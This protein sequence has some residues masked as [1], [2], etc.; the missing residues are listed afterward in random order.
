M[1]IKEDIKNLAKSLQIFKN[2]LDEDK[3]QLNNEQLCN[4][5]QV[6]LNVL[7]CP[8]FDNIVNIRGA[9]DQLKNELARHPSILP[10]D[11]EILKDGRLQLSDQISAVDNHIYGNC[12]PQPISIL[13]EDNNNINPALVNPNLTKCSLI[14]EKITSS[15]TNSASDN[16]GDYE[17]RRR[18]L[19]ESTSLIDKDIVEDKPS[20]EMVLNTEWVQV[21]AIELINDG[22]GLGFGIIGGRSTGV[23]VKNLTRGGPAD[24]DGRLQVGDHLLQINDI[25]IRGMSSEQV[26][27]VL[28]YVGMEVRLIV[29]RALDPSI[30]F[31]DL[32]T[33]GAVVPAHVLSDPEAIEQA[34]SQHHQQISESV[35][36][37]NSAPSTT[38][39]NE[40]SSM[41][42]PGVDNL[43]ET[44]QDMETLACDIDLPTK[45]SSSQ[46]VGMLR[47]P[48]KSHSEPFIQQQIKFPI[49]SKHK[50]DLP[51]M[52][53]YD[54]ELVKNQQGL[55]I[56]IA[57]YV[58]EKEEISG[59]FVKSIAPGSAADLCQKIEINDQIIEVDGRS[60]KNYTNHES[61]EV[62]RNTGKVVKLKLARY[63]RGVKYEQL[64]QAISDA[65]LEPPLGSERFV[66]TIP[67]YPGS[68]RDD[69]MS[70]DNY[71]FQEGNSD[72]SYPSSI[73]KVMEKS[74]VDKWSSILGPDYEIV[75]AQIRKFEE[76][77]GL[78]ISLEGTVDLEDGRK[79]RPHHYIRAILPDGPVG[80]NGL[81]RSGDE[82]LEVNGKELLRLD[83]SEVVPLL[84]ELPMNVCM[85]CA[86]S[87][88]GDLPSPPSIDVVD[89]SANYYRQSDTYKRFDEPPPTFHDRL[90]KTKSDGSLAINS[91]SSMEKGNRVKSRSLEPLSGS[92]LWADEIQ[93]IQLERG[94]RGLGFSIFDYQDPS[95]PYE[96]FIVIKDLVPGG[97]AE[98]D[99]R[100]N[101]GDRL[102]S[103]NDI[104]LG[105]SSLADA[106]QAL[107]GAPRGIVRIGV[108]KPLPLP[109]SIQQTP[110][111]GLVEAL[112]RIKG[113]NNERIDHSLDITDSS[114]GRLLQEEDEAVCKELC[115]LEDSNM[116]SSSST[117][118]IPN[119]LTNSVPPHSC[120]FS[121]FV[122]GDNILIST[123]SRA[124][125]PMD[126]ESPRSPT[127][128]IIC[129]T[130]VTPLPHALE[131]TLRVRKG[132]DPL[133]LTLEL[134]DRGINGMM[135]KALNPIGAIAKDGRLRVGDYLVAM[136][137]ESFRNVTNSQARAILRRAQL[138]SGDMILKYVPAEDVNV[139]KQ[140]T[141]L[142]LQHNNVPARGRQS[143][144]LSLIRRTPS[145][146]S[147]YFSAKTSES[148]SEE[149]LIS[150][151]ALVQS[152]CPHLELE[153]SGEEA[154]ITNLT[155]SKVDPPEHHLSSPELSL[156][157]D[158]PK[159]VDVKS[160]SSSP[161]SDPLMDVSH[162]TIS[163]NASSDVIKANV[164]PGPMNEISLD[165]N[166][167]SARSLSAA[168]VSVSNTSSSSIATASASSTL[169]RQW[170]A[171]KTIE[172]FREPD[173]GLGISIVGG[174][175]DLFN[176]S[177]GHSI[178]GIFIKNILPGSTAAKSGLLKR[179]D[180]ILEV[181]GKD[182]KNA[183]R[184]EAVEAIRNADNPIKFVVQSLLPLPREE[185]SLVS[186]HNGLLAEA[187]S[188][189]TLAALN[190][191]ADDDCPSERDLI[192]K[193]EVIEATRKVFQ[194]SMKVPEDVYHRR[195][196]SPVVIQEGLDDTALQ[197]EQA[198]MEMIKSGAIP[199]KEESEEN[200][201]T[202]S[203]ESKIESKLLKGKAVSLASEPTESESDEEINVRDTKG[204]VFTKAGV[205]IDRTSAGNV[206]TSTEE[207]DDPEDDFGYTQKKIQK[208]YGDLNGMVF[209]VELMKGPAGLGISLAGNRDRTK[210]S[211]FI[212]GM[213]PKGSAARDG[214]IQVSDEI[215]EVNGVVLY[216][217][218]HLNASAVIKSL[219]GPVYKII[220]L[221][222]EGALEEMAVK[223]L[224]QFPVHLEEEVLQ[225]KYNKFHGVRTVTVRKGATGLGI[226]II[227]GKHTEL[228]K[229]V[230]VSDIQEGSPAE[231][232]GLAVGDMILCVNQTDLI[233][234]DYDS[235]ASA[236]KN[237]EGLLSVVIAKPHRAPSHEPAQISADIAQMELRREQG[238][239]T[240]PSPTPSQTST[241]QPPIPPPKPTHLKHKSNSSLH[242]S[243]VN[244]NKSNG[245]PTHSTAQIKPISAH[246][247][248]SSTLRSI[249]PSSS[250][251]DKVSFYATPA[252]PLDVAHYYSTHSFSDHGKEQSDERQENP[253]TC[254]IECGRDTIIEIDKKKI[255][256]G[257]S[258]VGGS[259]TPLGA[260]IIHEV[261]PDGA[262]AVDGRL[263]PGDVILQVNDDDLH[264]VPHDQA[265]SALRQTT[266]SIRMVVH[267]EESH[268]TD[269]SDLY[270]ILTI[271]LNKKPG[272]GL[273]L[274]IVG[275]KNGPGV[276]VSEVVKGGVA[277]AD[278]RL[279]QGDHILQVNEHDLR[280]ATNADAAAILKT[281]M[282][283]IVMKIGRL[284]AGPRLSTSSGDSSSN[285][286]QPSKQD[287]CFDQEPTTKLIS[288]K[289]GVEGLGFS[290]VGGRGSP[291]GDFP[292]YVKNIFDKGAAAEDGRLQ[293]GDQIIAVNNTSL[294]DA[295]H[296]N[297]VE[298]LKNVSGVVELS[299]IRN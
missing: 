228:G 169:A 1:S 155:A 291:Y 97:L 296:E 183:T 154:L 172:L 197:E 12:P 38:L 238:L 215:L 189:T 119:R 82:I 195:T 116:Q 214:R 298:I 71:Y 138:I 4:D 258:V 49:D 254:Q 229:G 156:K 277:E 217:R 146:R 257:L 237:A 8:V 22:Q 6:L 73:N 113:P 106:V 143:P 107:K 179:G 141:L 104:N 280:N 253:K 80:K 236:L 203:K 161:K 9:L 45:T 93:F 5:V 88:T 198:R 235:A 47:I 48:V 182:L 123:D 96:T 133:G 248:S 13:P 52:E 126:Y 287:D 110:N 196:P 292:I 167:L 124:S 140:S 62:L 175:V 57:G 132:T 83:H 211:V 278:G 290:I 188:N 158:S 130:I 263:R 33:T 60:L 209:M 150:S 56:T 191:M 20:Q 213:H 200:E 184:D 221:R 10:L 18:K 247:S 37:L 151:D 255:G 177:P 160:A 293:R 131:R 260:V 273:G 103:V 246:T 30:D 227:E 164:P 109:E 41:P 275:K 274:S 101:P 32:Q 178:G 39:L 108:A 115:D 251:S 239:T 218:S 14:D 98:R 283:K 74:L 46:S 58:C 231:H 99:G 55:G 242:E 186:N 202:S 243:A 59:I 122:S 53:T 21:E 89:N 185:E 279:L 286:N 105:A 222:R 26:A 244:K 64:Q 289:K 193:P 295:T 162:G 135:I 187:S 63:L 95:N 3:R 77:G 11:F 192:S 224:T 118:S 61:V 28:R 259:D 102:L 147:P 226:M 204:K 87:K 294:D 91:P 266:S 142:A 90:V 163:N 157:T 173:Q 166:L 174:R 234:A 207:A 165:S 288:L 40:G 267:R 194:D 212:C 281:T 205:E 129:P 72:L 54:V 276:Y 210:M 199:S 245:I 127:S 282:G 181:D 111:Q 159:M 100:L 128:S 81:L 268:A 34:L 240:S 67:N 35:C 145:P 249:S 44:A 27:Q 170:S 51:E 65:E 148:G 120:P 86:R 168:N 70:L 206:K 23:I 75:V 68:Q 272:K 134:A 216:G 264:N 230:F 180:H 112:R 299:I 153:T 152:S 31:R 261:Y 19:S 233:G 136:N 114:F 43:R 7:E 225:E 50:I 36:S 16:T 29:A 42:I 25:N 144:L 284:K 208:K 69:A 232:A 285:I 117:S 252:A 262:A 297:A 85:V 271:E 66:P 190:S 84:K 137:S 94:D 269:D 241:H 15:I 270:E 171:P 176:L 256:L 17:S 149:N 201:E 121:P 125:T 139:H 220:L 92:G 76:G 24:Y 2:K 250:T 79:V 223:P 265:I 78:G 219:P